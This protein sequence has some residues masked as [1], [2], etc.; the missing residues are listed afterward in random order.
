MWLAVWSVRRLDPP[1]SPE[2]AVLQ[3]VGVTVVL[4]DDRGAFTSRDDFQRAGIDPADCQV[5][6]VKLGYLFPG[7]RPIAARA[8]MALS[9]GCTDLRLERLPYRHLPRPIYPLDPDVEWQSPS[10]I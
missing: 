10:Q 3:V 6:V 9:P 7:L 2:L 1:D 8:L 4:T 5:V